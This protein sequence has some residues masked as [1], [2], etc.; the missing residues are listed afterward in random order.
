[1]RT[2]WGGKIKWRVRT[3]T[4][5]EN[6]PVFELAELCHLLAVWSWASGSTSLKCHCVSHLVLSSYESQKL[7]ETQSPLVHPEVIIYLTMVAR[8][9]SG[10]SPKVRIEWSRRV[11]WL[12][13]N[14]SW[15][16]PP[17]QQGHHCPCHHC[18]INYHLWN[19][20]YGPA[21]H[22]KRST[23]SAIISRSH[24]ELFISCHKSGTWSFKTE[25]TLFTVTELESGRDKCSDPPD[26]KVQ[27]APK[28]TFISCF[29]F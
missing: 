6:R 15:N 29:A 12:R 8:T 17:H 26:Y 7:L 5:W 23:Y 11:F 28:Q 24:L 20:N 3:W 13:Q 1:M 18:H 25:C 9:T 14:V 2:F 27:G 4:V 21:Q 16:P 10:Q 22:Y 19:I